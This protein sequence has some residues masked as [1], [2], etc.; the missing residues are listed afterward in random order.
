MA[1]GAITTP[2]VPAVGSANQVVNNTGLP[3]MVVINGPTGVATGVGIGEAGATLTANVVTTVA[4]AGAAY[5]ITVLLLPGQAI[6]GF[7][8]AWTSWTWFSI[9]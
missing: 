1:L 3:L 7:T 9:G 2:A 5:V 6:A 8:N 4:L